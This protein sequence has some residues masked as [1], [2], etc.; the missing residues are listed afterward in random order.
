MDP[1]LFYLNWDL[2]FEVLISI[3]F[4]SFIVERALAWL[5]ESQFYI[6]RLGGRGLKEIIAF[7]L[8]VG[9]CYFVDFDALSI[10]FQ[11]NETHLFGLFI[12]GAVVSGGSKAS[13]K[14]FKEVWDSMSD[15]ERKRLQLGGK[16][17]PKAKRL[18]ISDSKTPN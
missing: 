2:L 4:L 18:D 3:I 8:S 17:G 10:L 5:F 11:R 9:V 12:T 14:L 15:A 7:A 6:N 1:N 16:L 13:I